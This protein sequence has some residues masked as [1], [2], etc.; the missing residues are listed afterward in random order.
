MPAKKRNGTKNGKPKDREGNAMR[1]GDIVQIVPDH[2]DY[3]VC[4]AVVTQARSWG[5]VV[6]LYGPERASETVR[7]QSREFVRVG[8]AIWMLD[9]C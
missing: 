4:F 8:H 5:C 9:D 2:A 1:T 6:E 3:P 7:L